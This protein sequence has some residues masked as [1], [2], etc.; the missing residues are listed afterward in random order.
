M[1]FSSGVLYCTV[2]E[3]GNLNDCGIDGGDGDRH[4][5]EFTKLKLNTFEV[6]FQTSSILPMGVE[7]FFV[8]FY[9][10]FVKK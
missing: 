2:E 4:F 3:K 10:R 1:E 7:Y 8:S 9:F 5:D 6:A